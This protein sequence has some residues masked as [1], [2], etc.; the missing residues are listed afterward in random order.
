MN[1][2]S[3]K[4]ALT[5]PQKIIFSAVAITILAAII[6][7]LSILLSQKPLENAYIRKIPEKI[8]SATLNLISYDNLTDIEN[9]NDSAFDIGIIV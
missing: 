2:K 6:V 5:A 4:N 9:K 7:C 1:E 8:N 3:K